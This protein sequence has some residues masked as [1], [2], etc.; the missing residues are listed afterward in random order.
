MLKLLNVRLNVTMTYVSG[1]K[2][3]KNISC[4]WCLTIIDRPN[5]NTKSIWVSVGFY[6]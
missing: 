5:T 4:G 6:R 3:T 2:R 1:D